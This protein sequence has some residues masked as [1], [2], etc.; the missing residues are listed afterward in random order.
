RKR[1]EWFT[2]TP[3]PWQQIVALDYGGDRTFASTVN[4]MVVSAEP[5]EHTK[6]EA[7]L[8][9]ALGQP[10]ITE[11]G[12]VFVCRML[13]LIG[14]AA[15]VPAVAPLLGDA[16]SAHA[17][18][19]ALDEIQDASVDVVYRNALGK[20]SGAA[21]VGLIGSIVRRRDVEAVHALTA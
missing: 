21:K 12:Q 19:I 16:R 17:A 14:T 8:I 7:K 9:E 10:G 2:A 20:L 4:R 15:C 11:A 13:G 1:T 5:A 18:R 3:D 6:M